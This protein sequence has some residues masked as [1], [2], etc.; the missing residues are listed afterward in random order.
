MSGPSPAFDHAP[1]LGVQPDEPDELSAGAGIDDRYRIL[2]LLGRGGMGSVYRAEH[3]ALKQTVAIK[4]L[5][6]SMARRGD[7]VQR[8]IQEARAAARIDHPAIVQVHDLGLSAE[9]V[10]IAM[11]ELQGEELR[12]WM[13][14]QEPAPIKE[15]VALIVELPDA[16]S[17]AHEDGIVHRDLKP[18][19]VFLARGRRGTRLKVL[20]FGIAKLLE[21]DLPG[22]PTT[23][24]GDVLGTPQYMSPEQ[25]RGAKAGPPVDVWAICAILFEAL[26]GR[27]AFVAP[28][29][30]AMAVAVM[31]GQPSSVRALRPEISEA[32]ADVIHKGLEKRPEDRFPNAGALHEALSAIDPVAEVPPVTATLVGMPEAP[33]PAGAEAPAGGLASSLAKTQTGPGQVSVESASAVPQPA[34]PWWAL[35]LLAGLAVAAI[36]AWQLWPAEESTSGA[37][38]PGAQEPPGASHPGALEPE[39]APEPEALEPAP[40]PDP[41]PEPG[42]LEP[43]PEPEETQARSTTETS[44]RPSRR[45]RQRSG[46]RRISTES[47]PPEP[48][49]RSPPAADPHR[50]IREFGASP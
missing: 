32:L 39:P 37:Q 28:T 17:A 24:T 6:S 48:P 27:P 41:A 8:F 29:Y 11:E 19:N 5:R 49:L 42:A 18:A 47:A 22:S 43:A 16:I 4:V 14:R 30:G 33:A 15:T 3:L 9:L 21:T 46:R 40:E 12:D 50:P 38:V 45:G 35:G 13:D 10:Y 26:T 23:R 44:E 31:T 2:G 34:R 25:F 7:A 1:T 20:D 36:A